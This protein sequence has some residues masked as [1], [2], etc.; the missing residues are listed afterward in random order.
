MSI[1]ILGVCASSLLRWIHNSVKPES[2]IDFSA[3]RRLSPASDSRPPAADAGEEN[4]ASNV[5]STTAAIRDD[6]KQGGSLSLSAGIIVRS[7]SETTLPQLHL[8]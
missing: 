7:W 8:E 2:S 3:G 1:N 6:L 5:A 4:V